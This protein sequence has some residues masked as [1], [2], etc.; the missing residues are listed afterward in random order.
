MNYWRKSKTVSSLRNRYRFYVKH[1]TEVD[2]KSI[3]Q[4]IKT[5]KTFYINFEYVDPSHHKSTGPR[6]MVSILTDPSIQL[7]DK[8][9]RPPKVEP[10]QF[11]AEEEKDAGKRSIYSKILLP[12]KNLGND[13]FIQN[14]SQ[15]PV[16][17]EY[18]SN[19]ALVESFFEFWKK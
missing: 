7:P 9:Q 6:R 5:K 17:N 15:Q 8:A 3:I 16:Y 18:T 11:K 4:N 13:Y 10:P 14:Q 19:Y 2:T 12:K 1:L